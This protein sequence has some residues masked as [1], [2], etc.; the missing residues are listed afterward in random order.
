MLRD[1]DRMATH[2]GLFAIIGR[3]GRGQPFPDKI[4]RVLPDFRFSFFLAVL[5]LS[6]SQMK[7]LPE[8]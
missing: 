5:I 7:A 3:N 8:R 4:C 2:G 6:P 1:E